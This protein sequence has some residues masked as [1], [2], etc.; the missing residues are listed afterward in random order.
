MTA[1]G[2]PRRRLDGSGVTSREHECLIS[3]RCARS[4][5][6]L[7]PLARR[8]RLSRAAGCRAP[9]WL[10]RGTMVNRA[11]KAPALEGLAA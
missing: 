1:A 2:G 6:G 7:S 11:E 10:L 9:F 4:H 3:A 5:H 8:P